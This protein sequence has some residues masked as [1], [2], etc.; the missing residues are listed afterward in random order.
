METPASEPAPVEGTLIIT[1]GPATR[2]PRRS[3]LHRP[4]PRRH[5]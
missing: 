3:S 1:R 5:R 4:R 2:P